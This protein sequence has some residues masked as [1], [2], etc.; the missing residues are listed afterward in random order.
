MQIK[1]NRL[2]LLSDIG[3]AQHLDDIASRLDLLDLRTPP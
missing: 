1:I 3:F 2:R